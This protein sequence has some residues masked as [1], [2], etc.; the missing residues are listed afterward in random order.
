[1][2]FRSDG[3][4]TICGEV[5]D[6]YEAYSHRYCREQLI[7]TTRQK[8]V[9]TGT[10]VNTFAKKQQPT[11]REIDVVRG[12]EKEGFERAKRVLESLIKRG[13]LEISDSIDTALIVLNE[14]IELYK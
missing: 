10:P 3:I 9:K 1:M 7:A 14:Q 6:D 13:E 4:C 5:L 8:D 11:N 2:A 12:Y